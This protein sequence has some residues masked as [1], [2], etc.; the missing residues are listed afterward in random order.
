M[1]II[2]T[3][4]MFVSCG[5]TPGKVKDE[6][7]TAAPEET[8]SETVSEEPSSIPVEEEQSTTREE[9]TTGSPE[10]SLTETETEEPSSVPGVPEPD[11]TEKE[12]EETPVSKTLTLY[13][14]GKEMPVTWEDNKSVNALSEL[15]ADGLTVQMS[16]YGGFEQVGSLGASLPRDDKQ[17]STAYGDIVLYQ[18]NQIVIFYGSNSWSYTS[19]GHIN[20]SQSEMT[21]LLSNG[22]TQVKLIYG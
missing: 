11:T 18:G 22:D 13:I 20:L 8:Q 9:T 1:A 2:T 7:T 3:L 5:K 10:V 16:M 14:D 19:L 6:N 12:T 21:E 4:Y 17:M 15:S